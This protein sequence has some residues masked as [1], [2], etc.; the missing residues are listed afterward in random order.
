MNQNETPDTNA[1]GIGPS[2]T[3]TVVENDLDAVLGTALQAGLDQLAEYGAV[4]PFAVVLESDESLAKRIAAGEDDVPAPGDPALRLVAVQPEGASEGDEID[5]AETV[6]ALID[7][8]RSQ[9]DDLVAVAIVS[10]VTL[11]EDD[12]DALHVA[13]EHVQGR[14]LGLLQPYALGEGGVTP[15]ELAGEGWDPQVF[16]D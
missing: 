9:R 1:E 14:S 7:A 5:G 4:M 2:E 3:G 15:G 12:S 6:A 8:L 16:T 11:A 10:D 13:G